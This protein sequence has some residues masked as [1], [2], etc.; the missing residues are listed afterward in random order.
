MEEEK[1][2][3][4]VG[5]I[6]INFLGDSITMGSKL[7]KIVEQRFTTLL[8]ANLKIKALNFG[9]SGSR[10]AKID[11]DKK[12]CFIDRIHRLQKS[13]N[14]TFIFGG[15]NDFKNGTILG[16]NNSEEISTFMEH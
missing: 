5:Q 4:N 9:I 12:K 8:E 14:F 16:D 2:T 3:N 6:K 15:I 7:R 10:I 1:I 13:A 11:S